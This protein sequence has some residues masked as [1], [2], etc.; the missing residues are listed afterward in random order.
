M[1]QRKL[2]VGIIGA[3][4]NY[5]WGSR[6]HIPALQALPQFQVVAVCTQHQET[7][8]E[9]ARKFNIPLAFSNVEEL[10]NHPD[11]DIVD[12]C[13]RLPAHHQIVMAALRAGKHVFCEWPLGVNTDE[14]KEMAELATAKQ[15][16]TMIGLQRRG[17]PGFNQ[18][19]SLV[20]DGYVGKVLSCTLTSSSAGFMWRQPSLTWTVDKSKGASTLSIGAGHSLDA[21]NYCL[22]DFQ[23]VAA[24]VS[25]QVTRTTPAA[26]G[27]SV[28]ITSPDNVIV[29]GV[30][31]GGAVA[32]VH[33]ASVMHHGAGF[34]LEVYGT[35]GT[36]VAT[37]TG[38]Q[39][40]VLTGGRG[41]DKALQVIPISSAHTWVP[42][43]VPQGPPLSV[44]QM[45]AHFGDAILTGKRV[46]ADFNHAVRLHQLLDAIQASSNTGEKQTV[47]HG[48]G[49][50]A[51][52][53]MRR[54]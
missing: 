26:P 7:A 33:I 1:E 31:E 37:S 5:G 20:A 32:S 9:T 28:D 12:V 48:F 38:P 11:V 15:V 47:P 3:N 46:E 34:R 49:T 41:G 42:A 44:G 29:S 39:D 4:V 10:V 25:T 2:R 35:E 43:G 13:V 36:L 52:T 51:T 21:L 30:L 17:S 18:L 6:A 45:F 40:I 53:S 54:R 23:E 22:G 27:E 14:A 19:R 8:Q 50:Q 24:R 16:R